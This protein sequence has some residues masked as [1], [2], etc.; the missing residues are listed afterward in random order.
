MT[1]KV[2]LI[3]PMNGLGER[4]LDHTE[5]PKPLI[6]I[7]N[8][9][10][11]FWLLDHLVLSRVSQIIIPYNSVLDNYGFEEKIQARYPSTLFRL[12]PLQYRTTGAA[13]TINVALEHIPESELKTKFMIMD[14]DTF[15][16]EDV[17]GDYIASK[18]S[19]AI[20]YFID[21]SADEIYSYITIENGLVRDIKEKEKI[22]DFANC[23]IFCAK[24]GFSLK[25]YCYVLQ[26]SSAKQKGEYYTSGIF[27]S[28][29]KNKIPVTA[30]EVGSFECVGTP[31]Q[32]EDFKRRIV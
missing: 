3:I 28:M 26:S 20:F 11:I 6:K 25:K 8:R 5:T 13:A 4:F 23:G 17:I 1:E 2:S 31:K 10:M 12:I 21:S 7:N 22:S 32:M 15:Y 16:Y 18:A 30:L 29:V 19:N 14:C 27:A 24:D 9:E